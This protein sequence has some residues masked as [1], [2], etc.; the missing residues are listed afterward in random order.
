MPL[1]KMP[2]TRKLTRQPKR[3]LYK[4]IK[5]ILYLVHVMYNAACVK[6]PPDHEQRASVDPALVS[7]PHR[8]LM[9]STQLHGELMAQTAHASREQ[10]SNNRNLHTEANFEPQDATSPC[11][12]ADALKSVNNKSEKRSNQPLLSEQRS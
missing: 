1:M 4:H 7:H 6:H 2:P 10:Q 11:Y 9:A 12:A 5:Y 8:K 3:E